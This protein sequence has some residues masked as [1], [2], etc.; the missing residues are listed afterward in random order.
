MKPSSTCS[1]EIKLKTSGQVL[2]NHS[3]LIPTRYFAI[4]SHQKCCSPTHLVQ[5]TMGVPCR[6]W[7]TGSSAKSAKNQLTARSD[8]DP[9]SSSSADYWSARIAARQSSNQ[10]GP[11]RRAKTVDAPRRLVADG[12]SGTYRREQ[13]QT[14]TGQSNQKE[15]YKQTVMHISKLSDL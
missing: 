6:A 4:V 3:R 2:S 13:S 14:P 7:I 8:I 11:G 12:S 10:S 1:S 15:L 5:N 9:I